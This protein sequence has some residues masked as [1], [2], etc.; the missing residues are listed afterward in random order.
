MKRLKCWW[1]LAGY[2]FLMFCPL[3][4]EKAVDLTVLEQAAVLRADACKKSRADDRAGTEDLL[5]KG[6]GYESTL[7]T[8]LLE[9][10]KTYYPHPEFPDDPCAAIDD[11]A[12]LI[13]GFD[14][15]LSAGTGASGYEWMLVETK[16][17]LLEEAICRMSRKIFERVHRAP[18]THLPTKQ[19]ETAYAEWFKK[20]N[21]L[22]ARER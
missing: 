13:V 14:Y 10:R 11:Y 12:K 21:D 22:R 18:D 5:I 2:Y 4:A 19:A 16:I 8:L 3:F 15:P 6:E 9:L 17:R 7:R 20:W 1:M